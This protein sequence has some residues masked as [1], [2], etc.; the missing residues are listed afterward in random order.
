[1]LIYRL[2]W[3]L[4]PVKCPGVPDAR[5]HTQMYKDFNDPVELRDHLRSPYWKPGVPLL[6]ERLQDGKVTDDVITSLSVVL[7]WNPAERTLPEPDPNVTRPTSVL[8]QRLAFINGIR[9]LTETALAQGLLSEENARMIR[10]LAETSTDG[11]T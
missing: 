9:E 2:S 10:Y 5:D 8:K 6:V 11:L 7:E 3:W 4:K 1:M